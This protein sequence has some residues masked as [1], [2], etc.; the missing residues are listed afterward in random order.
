MRSA[1]IASRTSSRIPSALRGPFIRFRTAA[2]VSVGSRDV[3]R[4]VWHAA[5]VPFRIIWKRLEDRFHYRD[6]TT[7]ARSKE[8]LTDTCTDG[9]RNNYKAV[10][11][12]FKGIEY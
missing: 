11:D 12:Y 1:E 2:G 9:C 7:L 5:S 3:R 8:Y 10:L 6:S 4:N